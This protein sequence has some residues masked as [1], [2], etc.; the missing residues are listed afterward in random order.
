MFQHVVHVLAYLGFI[1]T[2]CLQV[3]IKMIGVVRKEYAAGCA[4][5]AIVL[6]SAAY[7]NLQDF[8][9]F[10]EVYNYP[11]VTDKGA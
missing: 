2:L 9:T 7:Y 1:L 10:N 8:R 11:R 5:V 6:L 3:F 4:S